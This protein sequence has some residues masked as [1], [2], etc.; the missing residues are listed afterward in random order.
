MTE[1]KKQGNSLYTEMLDIHKHIFEQLKYAEAK[2]GIITTISLGFF[3][4]LARILYVLVED[5]N[6]CLF[7]SPSWIDWI[8]FLSLLV[9]IV[10][11]IFC[12][13][14]LLN[15]FNPRLDNV[16][17]EFEESQGN[18]YFFENI[19][20][21]KSDKFLEYVKG[22]FDVSK[23]KSRKALLDLSNQIC[24]LSQITSAKHRN[25]KKALNKLKW[26]F[27]IFVAF[28]IFGGLSTQAQGAVIM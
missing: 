15:A 4:V 26:I 18:V 10:L 12:L 9:C 13:W 24:V 28:L 3:A 20:I 11:C 22:K 1:N 25:C 17:N 21:T 23:L 7:T 16:E 2:C 19:A 5:K 14:D 27:P 6:L 8:A